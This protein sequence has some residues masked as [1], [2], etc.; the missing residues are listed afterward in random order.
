MDLHSTLEKKGFAFEEGVSE[1]AL[2]KL[3]KGL[4]E[5][6]MDPRSP[7]MIRAIVPQKAAAS[8]TNTLSSRYGVGAFPFHT[9]TAHWAKPARYLILYC[10]HSGEGKRPT[11]LQDSRSWK[12]SLKQQNAVCREVWKTGFVN[13]SLCTVAK[14]TEARLSI[15]FDRD[16]MS[17]MTKEATSLKNWLIALI[18]I[19]PTS[20]IS[21]APKC[22]LILD[23]HRMLHARGHSEIADE[24]RI[25]KRILIGD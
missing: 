8:K 24:G 21:W 11:L 1:R 22:L 3:V 7:E 6:R 16:C 4:G 17:P 20:E 14:M 25:L 5:M 18:D 15:R 2:L 9:D 19:T 10:V 23:N 12:L 13:P